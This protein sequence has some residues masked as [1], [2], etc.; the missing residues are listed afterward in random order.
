[1][2]KLLI[3]LGVILSVQSGYCQVTE[4]L[5]KTETRQKSKGHVKGNFYVMPGIGVGT[6]Y[7][8]KMVLPPLLINAE[9]GFHNMLSVGAMVGYGTAKESSTNWGV[10]SGHWRYNYFSLASRASFHWGR[11]IRIPEELDLYGR[12]ALGWRIRSSKWVEDVPTGRADEPGKSADFGLIA[13]VHAGAKYMLT[14]ALGAYL[15]IG[16]DNVSSVQLGVALKL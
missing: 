4:A 13:G 7:G 9:Y 3:S 2:K 11:Y 14:P 6:N 15:E 5:D 12:V 1:M 10:G 16:H 8:A